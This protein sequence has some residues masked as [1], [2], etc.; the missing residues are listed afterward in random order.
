MIYIKKIFPQDVN[1]QIAIPKDPSLYFFNQPITKGEEKKIT[2]I[3]YNID[4]T[5]NDNPINASIKGYDIECRINGDFKGYLNSTYKIEIGDIIAFKNELQNNYHFI[6]IKKNE[7]TNNIHRVFEIFDDNHCLYDESN[8]F[9]NNTTF[10]RNRIVFGAPG[11]GK[12]NK[13]KKDIPLCVPSFYI[14]QRDK[15]LEEQIKQE[16]LNNPDPNHIGDWGA[17]VAIKHS[18]YFQNL[19]KWFYSSSLGGK[20]NKFLL[21]TFGLSAKQPELMISAY[22]GLNMYRKVDFDDFYERVTFHPN[23][24]YAQFVGTYKPITKIDNV[25]KKEEIAYEY[26]PG[27]FIRTYIKSQKT[28]HNVLLLIEEINRANVAAVFGDVFQ[29]LDRDENGNSEYPITTSQDLRNFLAKPENLGGTPEDYKTLSIPSNMYIWATMN[30]ADQG[31]LPIDAAFKRRWDFEYIGIDDGERKE[32]GSVDN[33][34]SSYT[35]PVPSEYDNDKKEVTEYK[36]CSWNK[37]RHAINDKLSLIDGINEDKLLGP[38]FLSKNV[39]ECA[40]IAAELKE[41]KQ[42]ADLF[43]SKVLMY[44]YEDVVKMNPSDLFSKEEFKEGEPLRYSVLCN[45]FDKVGL[46]I[47]D[48]DFIN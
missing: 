28:N 26:V 45:K 12:S 19:E 32:D 20:Y 10:S 9:N 24:S 29:L 48:K 23:Y 34:F 5:I 4:G 11:T 7:I 16:I 47:F 39:L 36:P 43:K 13:L 1:N 3:C 35:I 44:L 42:Y 40:T 17:Y 25:T 27:P 6:Y 46:N 41:Q 37:I 14:F 38:Y 33:V 8:I 21:D 18:Q 30:S 31:V 2:F 15:L 22:R